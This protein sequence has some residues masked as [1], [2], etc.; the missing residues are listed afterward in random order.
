MPSIHNGLSELAPLSLF[1]S[2]ATF[3]TFVNLSLTIEVLDMGPVSPHFDQIYFA[4]AFVFLRFVVEL[5]LSLT[6]ITFAN[7]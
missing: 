3:A 6:L 4:Q 1:H 5:L 2:L 7:C